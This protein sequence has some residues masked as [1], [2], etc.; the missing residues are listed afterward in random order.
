MLEVLRSLTTPREPSKA[1]GAPEE[2]GRSWPHGE[3]ERASPATRAE[4][5]RRGGTPAEESPQVA[6]SRPADSRPLAIRNGAGPEESRPA[7]G[8]RVIHLR[9]EEVGLFFLAGVVLVVMAFLMGW[10]GRGTGDSRRDAFSGA[11]RGD[12]APARRPAREPASEMDSSPGRDLGTRPGRV[13]RAPARSGGAYSILV[14]RFPPGGAGDAED[15]RLFL[16]QRGYPARVRPTAEGIELCVGSF[17][18]RADGLARQWLPKL[19][20]L[21]PAYSSACIVRIP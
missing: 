4:P 18:S 16:E 12:R 17:G 9:V 15:H 21:S 19:R 13:R 11:A 14:A 20:K 10:Y 5:L 6:P 2:P 3:G 8:G 7:S 1:E